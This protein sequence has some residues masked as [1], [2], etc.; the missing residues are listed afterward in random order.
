MGVKQAIYN[1]HI[2]TNTFM[3]AKPKIY[4]GCA[5]SHSPEEFK[6]SIDRF[7]DKLRPFA[8]ILDFLGLQHPSI[9]EA[10]EWDI[11]CVKTC[12][13]FI[14]NVTHPSIGLGVEFGTAIANRKPVITI[15]QEQTLVRQFVA[16]YIN[17][18]HFMM[19][20]QNIDEAAIYVIK[21]MRELFPQA[22]PQEN[23]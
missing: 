20:Y 3:I 15:A 19:R 11:N 17:P 8:E 10:F 18:M 1:S 23:Y 21:K 14:A 16:G 2:V 9:E 13:L 22:F 12:D 6:K 4:V 5:L 7:K